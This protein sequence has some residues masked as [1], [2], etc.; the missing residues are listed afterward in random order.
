[1]SAHRIEGLVDKVGAIEDVASRETALELVRAVMDLHAEGLAKLMEI[2]SANEPVFEACAND[3]IVSSILLLHDLHPLDLETRVRRT[4]ES[5]ALR[6]R[7]AR[8]QLREIR[9]GVVYVEIDGGPAFESAVR[10][11]LMDAAPDAEGVIV[12]SGKGTENFVPL[13]QRVGGQA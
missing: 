7:G 1:M 5:P 13:A 11:A 6:V 10:K 12:N 9:D 3:S 2:I 4:L 8:A